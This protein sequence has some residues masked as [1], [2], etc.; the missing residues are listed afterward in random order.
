MIEEIDLG[1][2]SL[3]TVSIPEF[4][5]SSSP[6]SPGGSSVNFGGGIEM[7]MN[8]KRKSSTKNSSSS[9]G[10]GK[11]SLGDLETLENELNELSGVQKQPST[12]SSRAPSGFLD[13]ISQSVSTLW[14][15][16]MGG[17]GAAQPISARINDVVGGGVGPATKSVVADSSQHQA[18]TWDGFVKMAAEVPMDMTVSGAPRVS[19]R[20]K[21][22]KKRAMIKK[23]E[24]WHEKGTLKHSSHFTLDSDYDEVEDEYETA[25]DEKRQKDSVKLQGW[26]F[27]TVVNSIE[28]AN[29]VFNPFDL[30]LDGWGEQIGED[31]DSYDD[32]F[33]ELHDKYKG[34][35]ISP[36]ISLLLRVGFSAAVVNI[37]NKALS[38]ATPGF[39]DIIKQ[40]PEL[41][42]MFT[43]ATVQTMNKESQGFSMLNGMTGGGGGGGGGGGSPQRDTDNLFGPPPQPVETKH[44]SKNYRSDFQFNA[45]PTTNSNNRPDLAAARGL[46]VRAV[47]PVNIPPTRQEMRGPQNSDLDSILSGLKKRGG[48]G[49]GG[50]GGGAGRNAPPRADDEGEDDD[51]ILSI[52]SNNYDEVGSQQL[53]QQQQQQKPRQQQPPL[54]ALQKKKTKSDKNIVSLDI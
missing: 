20:D 38:T 29:S 3:E 36:E 30:N 39:N 28:Y 6:R 19:D 54:R 40:S 46:P 51:D 16:A 33:G 11:M 10:G 8:D 26:W 47:A 45:R 17:G 48:A 50:G 4:A 24:E 44:D 49:G 35:K 7:L 14:N 31:I 18:K 15:G 41:M 21:R 42:K 9:P 23:L 53:Y 5:S 1:F 32:I 37:T 22:R 12:S 27:M 13:D 52:T 34:G 25:M 43:N 2:S